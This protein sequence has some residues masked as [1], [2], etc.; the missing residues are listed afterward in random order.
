MPL[1]KSPLVSFL[2]KGLKENKYRNL[3]YEDES[4]LIFSIILPHKTN[5]L[6]AEDE[7]IFKDWYQLKSK[8][9][10]FRSKAYTK[11]KQALEASLKKSN[12]VE[13]VYNKQ[14][15]LTYRILKEEE[16]KEKKRP[17]KDHKKEIEME[18]IPSI[19][20]GFGSAM[21]SPKNGDSVDASNNKPG[22]DESSQH[23]PTPKPKN[24]EEFFINLRSLDYYLGVSEK[25]VHPS[26]GMSLEEKWRNQQATI[27][28]DDDLHKTILKDILFFFKF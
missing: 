27:E 18:S 4:E 11:A 28:S 24:D 21:D 6:C 1:L 12:Y 23:R 19:D 16:I 13:K 9:Y 20:S 25:P 7:K 26:P 8:D 22:E 17:K 14:K 15:K 3:F 2:Q 10:A 5:Q